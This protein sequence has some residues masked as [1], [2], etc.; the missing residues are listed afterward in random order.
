MRVQERECKVRFQYPLSFMAGI[1]RLSF[2]LGLHRTEK[3][4]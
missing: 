1:E 3:E 4:R 2:M